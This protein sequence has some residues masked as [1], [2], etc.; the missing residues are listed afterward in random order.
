MHV[1]VFANSP[2]PACMYQTTLLKRAVAS[3]RRTILTKQGLSCIFGDNGFGKS[4]LLRY[5]EASY[6]GDDNYSMAF[7]ANKN[8]NI[9][10]FAFLREIATEFGVPTQRSRFAQLDVIQEFL[11]KQ[12]EEGKTVLLLVDEAQAL[13]AE[14]MECIRSL[15]NYET[16]T[17]KLCQIVMAGELSLRDR[18]MTR[19]YKAFK[20]RVVTPAVLE[21][22]TAD[23]TWEM[24]RFRHDHW[25]VPN[26]FTVEAANRI[27]EITGGVPR[28]AVMLAGLAYL[29]AE[30]N[31]LSS[32][33]EHTVDTAAEER[34]WSSGRESLAA[35]AVV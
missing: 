18:M 29:L 30:E 1:P 16:A 26:K 5:I 28:E 15:L 9:S 11:D 4:S 32:I 31:G 13:P 34:S 35:G 20:S 33:R 7:L 23:E 3:I 12:N 21:L 24:I 19:R 6:G 8:A 14:T 25:A 27:H 10:P 2:D 17:S 22:F